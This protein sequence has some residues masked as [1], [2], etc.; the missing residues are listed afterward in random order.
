MGAIVRGY[1]VRPAV[2]EQVQSLG[3]E[4]LEV[5]DVEESG[6]GE[7][8]FGPLVI[9]VCFGSLSNEKTCLKKN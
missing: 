1:D 9:Q 3:G 5:T 6:E 7:C 8:S 2:K 4:F